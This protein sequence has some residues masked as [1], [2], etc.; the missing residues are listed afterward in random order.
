MFLDF[1]E[2]A[3]RIQHRSGV[4]SSMLVLHGLCA[5]SLTCK[6]FPGSKCPFPAPA[7]FDPATIQRIRSKIPNLNHPHPQEITQKFMG[8]VL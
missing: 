5:S 1:E 4:D 6:L 3:L 7:G 2:S 8:K